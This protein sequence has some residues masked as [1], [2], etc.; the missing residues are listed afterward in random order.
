MPVSLRVFNSTFV[1]YGGLLHGNWFV[2]SNWSWMILL[3]F[4]LLNA[5]LSIPWMLM[6]SKRTVIRGMMIGTFLALSSLGILYLSEAIFG[7]Y[8]EFGWL[9]DMSL[10]S[11]TGSLLSLAIFTLTGKWSPAHFTGMR[12]LAAALFVVLGFAPFI[13]LMTWPDILYYW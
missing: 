13:L 11:L 9:S 7:G 4:V 12:L 3:I 6:D 1:I 8:T 10:V 5:A 2:W